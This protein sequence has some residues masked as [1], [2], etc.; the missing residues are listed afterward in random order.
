MQ[1]SINPD[2]FTEILQF[3]FP[4]L[5]EAGLVSDKLEQLTSIKGL[6]VKQKAN[7]YDIL[8]DLIRKFFSQSDINEQLQLLTLA[9][10]NCS[11]EV[12]SDYFGVSKHLIRESR[13][14]LRRGAILGK[15]G[16]KKGKLLKV[17]IGMLR[18]RD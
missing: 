3:E 4:M 7:Q 14:L 17:N 16:P 11:R 8:M 10:Q 13:E 5:E 6:T 1:I 12:L 2:K 15:V 9:P 18:S